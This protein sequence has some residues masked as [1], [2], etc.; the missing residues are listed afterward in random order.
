MVRL[1]HQLLTIKIIDTEPRIQYSP[2][3]RIEI[4]ATKSKITKSHVHHHV[5]V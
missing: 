5:L 4:V 2:N 1:K 3:Y